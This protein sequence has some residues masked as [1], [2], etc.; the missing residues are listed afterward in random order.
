MK[1]EIQDTTDVPE[2]MLHKSTVRRARSMHVKADLLNCIGD[3]WMSQ[4]KILKSACKTPV[5]CSIWK[6]VTINSQELQTG[7]NRCRRRLIVGHTSTLKYIKSILMLGQEQA[8][9]RA[10]NNHAEE[11]V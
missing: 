9:R 10:T 4:C 6:Q 2:N 8:V 7:V 5:I 11:V 3:V 1:A